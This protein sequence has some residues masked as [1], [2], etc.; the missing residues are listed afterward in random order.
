[1][2]NLGRTE[3]C[4]ESWNVDSRKKPNIGS[5]RFSKEKDT[6]GI[7]VGV[8]YKNKA[9]ETI[10]RYKTRLE[11]KRHIQTYRYKLSRNICAIC[12]NEYNASP[13]TPSW[14]L[15]L[16]VIAIWC[17]EC[18]STFSCILSLSRLP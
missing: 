12:K 5:G 9:D 2:S 13:T 10:N 11:I 4:Y 17:K 16:I 7:Q 1:M 6:H 8:Y 14:Q 3:K 15:W 18:L